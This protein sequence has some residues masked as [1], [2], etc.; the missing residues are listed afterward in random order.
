[1]NKPFYKEI[2]TNWANFAKYKNPNGDG[3]TGPW[4]PTTNENLMVYRLQKG[5]RAS[6]M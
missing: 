4:E 1:M 6:E 3:E 5:W 2:R